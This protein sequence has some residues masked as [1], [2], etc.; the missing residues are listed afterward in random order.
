MSCVNMLICVTFH[1][2]YLVRA[3]ML[4]C[5]HVTCHVLTCHLFIYLRVTVFMF[6]MFTCS[7][8]TVF[9]CHVFIC[10]CIYMFTCLR[11]MVFGCHVLTGSRITI[12]TCHVFT[13]YYLSHVHMFMCS[14]VTCTQVHVIVLDTNLVTK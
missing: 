3:H 8:L 13:Y 10:S 6:R 5:S 14:H 12:F 7:D 9:T 4:V 11:V 1:G 2:I